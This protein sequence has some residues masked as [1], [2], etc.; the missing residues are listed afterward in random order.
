VKRVLWIAVGLALALAAV[1]VLRA[2]ALGPTGSPDVPAPAPLAV[3]G[4]AVA[5][6]LAGALRLRTVSYED[7]SRRDPQTFEAFAA[8]LEESWPGV[9]ATLSRERIG[10]YSLLYTWP[11]RNA[12]AP[13]VLLA[14]HHDVVP[15]DHPE[16]WTRPPFDGVIEDGVVWGRGSLDDKGSLVAILEAVEMLAAAGYEPER[17]LYLAF[18]HDEE[19][20]GDE[21]AAAIAAQLAARGVRLAIVVDEGGAVAD[22]MVSGIDG[23]VAVVGIAEKGSVSA[24]LTADMPGGH[25]SMPPPSSNV[26]I[27]AAA[28][29]ALE[30]NPMPARLEGP[31]R[32][33]FESLAPAL[34]FGPRLVVA[35]LWL[36]EPVLLPALSAEPTLDAMM[37]TTT[38]ATLFHAGVKPNVLPGHAEAV[39]NF[40][41]LAPDTV[42]DVLDHVRRTIDDERIEVS[43]IGVRRDPSPESPVDSEAFAL[44]GRAIRSHFGDAVVAPYLVVGG[45]DARHY[46][47]LT[48]NVYRFAPFR[49][50]PEDRSLLHGTDERV[51]VNELATAVRFYH[52]LI[53]RSTGSGRAF[54]ARAPDPRALGK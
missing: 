23:A 30:R 54:A 32:R 7:R 22:G 47:G 26:G 34:P 4:D 49:L 51:R 35:N 16:S 27:V 19:L 39:V 18:G 31:V 42:E 33:L 14:A 9:H 41:I 11:G 1:V 8:Y 37:R 2:L 13:G 20:G 28:V 15:V 3:D 38:A 36:F 5:R 53:E 48:R 17:T 43:T 52:T 45:T 21:G 50:G 24:V 6:R 46:Q 40:R 29:R 44:L 10:G 12:Q 25:S